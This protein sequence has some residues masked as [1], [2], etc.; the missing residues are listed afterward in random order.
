MRRALY[1]L[2]TY[3]EFFLL[4]VLL[5]P[6]FAIVALV[7]RNTDPTNRA[8]GRLMRFFGRLTSSITPNWRFRV[9]G[10]PPSDIAGRAYVVVCN[11]ESNADPFLLSHLPFDMRFVAKDEL[12]RKPLIGWLLYLGGDIRLRRG[13]KDSIIQM[14]AECRRTLDHGLPVM[15]FPEGTRSRDGKLLPFKDGAF[16]LAIEAGVPVLPLVVSG[17]RNCMPKHSVWFGVARASVRILAPIDTTGMTLA[18]VAMLRDK[19]RDAIAAAST[20]MANAIEPAADRE[21]DRFPLLQRSARRP[22]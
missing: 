6:V 4:A 13:D 2:Y 12:F 7:K 9:E 15:L 17:T 5:L 20:E 11:H 8:R 21:G 18:D 16:R 22:L 1:G 19:T 10:T 14:L 3:L